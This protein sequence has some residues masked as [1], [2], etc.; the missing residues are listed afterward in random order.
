VNILYKALL[1]SPSLVHLN[2]NYNQISDT[3]LTQLA[4]IISENNYLISLYA[5]RNEFGSNGIKS[6]HEVLQEK[7]GKIFLDFNISLIDGELQIYEITHN[8]P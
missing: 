2:L 5:F 6:F 4:N 3:G 8:L 7:F 1:E